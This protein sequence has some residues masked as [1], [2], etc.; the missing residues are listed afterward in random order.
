MR[1]SHTTA[2]GGLKRCPE[3]S[4]PHRVARSGRTP[5]DVSCCHDRYPKWTEDQPDTEKESCTVEQVVE[6]WP[7]I[8]LHAANGI[9][10]KRRLA[11]IVPED[12]WPRI[13]RE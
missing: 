7:A 6:Q 9:L 2:L 12:R 5:A 8:L 11:A 3:I 4:V 10:M 1:V 13:L